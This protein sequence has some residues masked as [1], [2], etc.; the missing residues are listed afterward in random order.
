LK[1]LCGKSE[2]KLYAQAVYFAT[3]YH[4]RNRQCQGI[5]DKLKDNAHW[6]EFERKWEENNQYD[7]QHYQDLFST[8]D[9]YKDLCKQSEDSTDAENRNEKL[10]Y[11][12]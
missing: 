2:K 8:F 9:K 6:D 3:Y 5:R 12:H 7:E 4:N 11:L 10:K 1:N